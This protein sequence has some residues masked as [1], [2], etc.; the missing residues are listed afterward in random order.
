MS[1]DNGKFLGITDFAATIQQVRKPNKFEAAGVLE[2]YR[3]NL[4]GMPA[5]PE[6]NGRHPDAKVPKDEVD[7]RLEIARLEGQQE[8]L[9]MMAG[10]LGLG[11]QLGRLDAANQ[12][13]LTQQQPPP[14]V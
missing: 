1:K 11:N 3:D 6:T 5:E 2:R 14:T 4:L 10:M 9:S 7:L 13:R 8:V 12:Q